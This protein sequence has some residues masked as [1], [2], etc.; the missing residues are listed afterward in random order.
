MRYGMKSLKLKYY[1]DMTSKNVIFVFLKTLLTK[2]LFINKYVLD[3]NFVAKKTLELFIPRLTKW[4]NGA[5]FTCVA[6]QGFPQ[7]A[8]PKATSRIL[9][10]QCESL[11][12]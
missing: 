11:L 3:N 8:K 2:V 6:D 5:N 10:V 7:L 4:D 1:I 12:C 9:R